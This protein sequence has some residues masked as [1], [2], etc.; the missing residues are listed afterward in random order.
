MS[1][2]EGAPGY[3]EQDTPLAFGEVGFVSLLVSFAGALL[4]DSVLV[5]VDFFESLY[6]SAYQP[7]PFSWKELIEMS[8]FNGPL[9][10]GQVESGSSDKFCHASMVS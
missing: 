2:R 10:A 9:Q 5:V 4:V 7:P 3:A 1:G 6:P 8:F